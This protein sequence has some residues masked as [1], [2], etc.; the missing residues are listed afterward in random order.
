VF[1]EISNK[2]S[3]PSFLSPSEV[4]SELRGYTEHRILKHRKGFYFWMLI[5][6]LTVPFI[7]IPIIPNLPFFFC[8]W[9][10][11]SHYR[12]Y[13]SS[14]Y[15]QS[16][17]DHDIIVPETSEPLDELYK[18]C[19]PKTP[20]ASCDDPDPFSKSDSSSSEFSIPKTNPDREPQHILLGPEAVP[21]ILSL[22]RFE[23][24]TGVDLHRAIEQA[25]LR[26]ASG[27]VDL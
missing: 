6:P 5:A 15:L 7:I 1:S 9:R 14:Q 20:P 16:L 26:V 13:R 18:I 4:L 19:A 27:R 24:T 22:F 2:T 23:S 10:S 3:T 8:A 25:R 17:L 12:A 11:W 21:A